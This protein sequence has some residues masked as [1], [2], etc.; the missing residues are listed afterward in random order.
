MIESIGP[1]VVL[2]LLFAH[3]PLTR[4]TLK[5][6]VEMLSR[7]RRGARCHSNGDSDEGLCFMTL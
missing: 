3:G 5:G 2:K 7:A 4:W 1:R 6:L